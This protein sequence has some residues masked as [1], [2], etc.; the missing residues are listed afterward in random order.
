MTIP[1]SA[2]VTFDSCLGDWRIIAIT[3]GTSGRG[4]RRGAIR[5]DF[6]AIAISRTL[7]WLLSGLGCR[8]RRLSRG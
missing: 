1:G 4:N 8:G 6:F 7:P 5:Q 3:L 2:T